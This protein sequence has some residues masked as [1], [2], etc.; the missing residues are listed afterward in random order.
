MKRLALFLLPILGGILS[1]LAWPESPLFF[2]IFIAWIPILLVEDHFTQQYLQYKKLAQKDKSVKKYRSGLRLFPLAY[3]FFLTWNVLTTW[4]LWYA[5]PGGSIAANLLNSLFMCIPFLLFHQSRKKFGDQTGYLSLIVFWLCFE[6]L[7][8]Q[9]ELSWSWLNLGN[10][11]AKYPI[12]VQWYEFTGTSGGTLWVLLLNILL[13]TQTKKLALYSPNINSFG[14][15]IQ[16]FSR[17]TWKPILALALPILLSVV[18][19]STYQEKG[20]EVEIVVLQPNIDPY[21]KFDRA[22]RSKRMDNFLADSR[23][24]V[25]DSTDYVLWPETNIPHYIQLNKFEDYKSIVNIR[26]LIRDYPKLKFVSGASTW[27]NYKEGEE[28]SPTARYSKGFRNYYE[29]YNSALQLDSREGYQIYHKSKLVPGSER[30]PYAQYMKFLENYMVDLG[31]IGGSLGIQDE[32]KVF[33]SAEGIKVAP[34]ICYESIY[35]DYVTEYIRKGANLIFISTNDAW[36]NETNGH[37]H[38][39]RYAIFRA[40]ENRR[41][42]ARSANTG[43]SCFIDQKGNIHQAT[44]YGVPDVIKGTVRANEQITFYTKYGDLLSR[45]CL[46]LGI[47]LLLNLIVSG[48]TNDFRFIGAKRKV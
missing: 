45:I 20:E 34:V 12:F 1:W 39:L 23:S 16:V 46:F 41:S 25:S 31:G 21:S 8:Q 3:L 19:Y 14:Q 29:S 33:D 2:F 4:W 27:Y 13:L 43:V 22:S 28:R 36:W 37:R 38:H 30:M 10:V 24:Q 15:L 44:Q 17:V 18:I 48:L 9:W 40:I 11:F 26:K 35:G 5:T 7:H 42:I 32:R 6:Y 47:F